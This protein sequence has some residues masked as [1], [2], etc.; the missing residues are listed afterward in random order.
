MYGCL[1]TFL[2][3]L[4]MY[5]N[6]FTNTLCGQKRE[7]RGL[8]FG[9]VLEINQTICNFKIKFKVYVDPEQ[10]RFSEEFYYGKIKL[11]VNDKD[12][13]IQ[14]PTYYGVGERYYDFEYSRS[15]DKKNKNI[16]E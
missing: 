13:V 6:I 5:T 2:S 14:P 9:L 11:V 1:N 4:F 3:N 16:N 10:N 15:I 8:T 7:I 12:V